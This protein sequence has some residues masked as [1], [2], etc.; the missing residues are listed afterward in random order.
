MD[1]ARF[2]EL[3]HTWTTNR[4]LGWEHIAVAG[5]ALRELIWTLRDEGLTQCQIGERIGMSRS[6]VR[7]LL[8]QHRVLNPGFEHVRREGH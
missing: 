2:K 6:R 5:H 7:E 3:V 8:N 1:D 4:D